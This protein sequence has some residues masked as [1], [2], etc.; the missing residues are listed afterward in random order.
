[1]ASSRTVAEVLQKLEASIAHKRMLV[2]NPFKTDKEKESIRQNINDLKA[3]RQRLWEGLTDWEKESINE[4][5]KKEKQNAT[6]RLAGL[7]PVDIVHVNTANLLG[8]SSLPPAVLAT[9]GSRKQRKGKKTRGKNRKNK[10]TRKRY[11]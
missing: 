10:I 5:R 2:E 3:R 11:H 6:R 9:G 1:M 7:P 8:L 4:I